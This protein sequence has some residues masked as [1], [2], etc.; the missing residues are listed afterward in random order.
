MLVSINKSQTFMIKKNSQR[1]TDIN[2]TILGHQISSELSI[3]FWRNK[4]S[5]K[6]KTCTKC[7]Y[8]NEVTQYVLST[9]SYKHT[10]TNSRLHCLEMGPLICM[11]KC[12]LFLL[13]L[14]NCKLTIEMICFLINLWRSQSEKLNFVVYFECCYF[15]KVHLICLILIF[16][17]LFFFHS[18]LTTHSWNKDTCV[19]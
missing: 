10:E 11:N 2:I 5:F 17:F 6:Y 13:T 16:I 9:T 18:L 19:K 15:L 7:S 8:N 14:A 1:W 3:L 4:T 12:I